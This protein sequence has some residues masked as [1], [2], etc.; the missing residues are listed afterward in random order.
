MSPSQSC[1]TVMERLRRGDEDAS[2]EVFTR[3]VDRLITVAH[4]Q[5]SERLRYKIDPEDVVQSVC[6]SFFRRQRAGQF[7]IPDWESLWH[8]LTLITIRKCVNAVEHWTAGKRDL[9]LE[10]P[11]TTPAP[12]RE[13]TPEDAAVLTETLEQLMARLT[14]RE[15]EILSLHLQGYEIS[16]I[17]ERVGRTRRTVRRALD[18]ARSELCR[19]QTA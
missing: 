15:Q 17:G 19:L 18:H 8:L 11:L 7:Q 14:A 4:H 13:P 3:F 16:E 2:T 6:R 1:R 12:S 10:L 9:N 5:L